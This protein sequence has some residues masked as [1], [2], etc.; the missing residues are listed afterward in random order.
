MSAGASEKEEELFGALMPAE[1]NRTTYLSNR[2]LI[3]KQGKS[4]LR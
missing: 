4:L 1:V 2:I 3:K